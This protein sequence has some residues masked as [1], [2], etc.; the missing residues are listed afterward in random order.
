MTLGAIQCDPASIGLFDISMGAMLA[1]WMATAE[2]CVAALAHLCRFLNFNSWIETG[3]HDLHSIYF[4]I[5]GILNIAS[6]GKI[7]G[8]P[9][10][11]PQFVEIENQDPLTPPHTTYPT[12]VELRSRDCHTMQNLQI[13]Q[14]SK[15]RQI[16]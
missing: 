15:V 11:R 14:D 5:S 7:A 2:F 1:Y 12:L 9:C 8:S 10:P 16:S 3:I 13:F 4:T 6:N